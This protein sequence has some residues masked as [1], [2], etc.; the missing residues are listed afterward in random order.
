M[1]HALE[2]A[3]AEAGI[4]LCHIGTVAF[5]RV[6]GLFRLDDGDVLV[7]SLVGGCPAD[8]DGVGAPSGS[9]EDLLNRISELSPEEV[10]RLLAAHQG[11]DG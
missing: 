8:G 2:L 6:R 9:A 10:Q 5:D 11:S 4:G 1:S 7:H 3:A